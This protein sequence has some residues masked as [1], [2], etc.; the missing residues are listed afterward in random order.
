MFSRIH[1][2]E[3]EES[4][5][6]FIILPQNMRQV[7]SCTERKQSDRRL[8]VFEHLASFFVRAFLLQTLALQI[9]HLEL[10]EPPRV[11]PP[12]PDQYIMGFIWIQKH[13]QKKT[14]RGNFRLIKYCIKKCGPLTGD[15]LNFHLRKASQLLEL[16]NLLES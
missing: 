5:R 1:P 12:S 11:I 3:T 10:L 8:R 15:P 14:D 16:Y 2:E 7:I 13:Y 6:H 4:N 9:S